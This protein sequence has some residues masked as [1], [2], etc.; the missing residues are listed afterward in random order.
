[1]A[2]YDWFGQPLSQRARD[3]ESNQDWYGCQFRLTQD[4]FGMPLHSTTTTTTAG[5]TQQI[6][7]SSDHDVKRPQP[8]SAL[9]A[10][11]YCICIW[12]AV[13]VMLDWAAKRV[14]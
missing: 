2:D 13:K 10:V 9:G 4:H 14:Y 5:T 7:S 3:E 11:L 12:L 8:S 1:M 6:Q